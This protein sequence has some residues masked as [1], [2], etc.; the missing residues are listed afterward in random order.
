[1]RLGRRM[2]WRERSWIKWGAF[3]EIGWGR[4]NWIFF[5]G[6]SVWSLIWSYIL[7]GRYHSERSFQMGLE[8]DYIYTR[9]LHHT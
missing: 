5:H 8:S 1:M 7:N 6:N 3:W 4:V 2:S 9:R